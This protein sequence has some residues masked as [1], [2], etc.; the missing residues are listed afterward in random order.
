MDLVKEGLAAKVERADADAGERVEAW[1]SGSFNL[2]RNDGSA[3]GFLKGRNPAVLVSD[4]DH[5]F[6]KAHQMDAPATVAPAETPTLPPLSK[7][8]EGTGAAV[9]TQAPAADPAADD[10]A[11][12]AARADAQQ[13]LAD[14]VAG[15]GAAEAGEPLAEPVEPEEASQAPARS[16]KGK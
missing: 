12:A 10:A 6:V 1:F 15:K 11:T 7:V 9:A 3:V 14:A 13:Q 5:W 4:L 2:I 16:A 8:V